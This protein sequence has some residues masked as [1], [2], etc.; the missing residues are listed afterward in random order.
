MGFS[1]IGLLIAVFIFLPNLLFMIYP[2]KNVPDELKDAGI[3]FTVLERIGQVA[4]LVILVISRDSYKNVNIDIWFILMVLCVILYYSLWVR[5][6]VKG[7]D[8]SLAFKPLIFIPI[9]MAIFP[10]LAFGFAAL[11]GKSISLVIAVVLLA[12][13]H[14]VN[15]W[16]TYKLT[17]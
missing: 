3:I 14:F 2:P 17:K 7:H 9:P 12:I 5:Y 10:V 6:V 8:L 16:N 13:G 1:I 15:S 11:W 4:C